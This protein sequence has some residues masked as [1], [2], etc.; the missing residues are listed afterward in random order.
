MVNL[1][2]TAS[3]RPEARPPVRPPVRYDLRY[4]AQQRHFAAVTKPEPEAG[5]LQ[6]AAPARFAAQVAA[7]SPARLTAVPFRKAFLLRTG[8]G[9]RHPDDCRH[10]ERQGGRQQPALPEQ[11]DEPE[12]LRQPVAKPYFPFLPMRPILQNDIFAAKR[13]DCPPP[14]PFQSVS[15]D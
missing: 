12:P 3:E 4:P 7:G 6:R 15:T 11:P 1:K 9:S 8:A 5:H 13:P 2:T 10:D 14:A